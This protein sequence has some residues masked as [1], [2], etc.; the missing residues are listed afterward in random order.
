MPSATSI[1]RALLWIKKHTKP[2]STSNGFHYKI[3]LV[4]LKDSQLL[5]RY[6]YS[7][8]NLK[9]YL[10][11]K[12]K[13]FKHS[14]FLNHLGTGIATQF[15]LYDNILFWKNSC[16][17]QSVSKHELKIT[18]VIQSVQKLKIFQQSRGL[19]RRQH[20]S[21]HSLLLFKMD[22]ISISTRCLRCQA[23]VTPICKL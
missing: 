6:R 21:W 19:L 8:K 2:L 22:Y 18:I 12:T 20:H 9:E 23:I 15:R 16:S 17:Q 5:Y 13:L 4:K 11:C 10:I 1:Y 14:F 7:F 3:L